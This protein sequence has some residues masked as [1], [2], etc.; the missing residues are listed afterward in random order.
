M[1]QLFSRRLLTCSVKLRDG[2]ESSFQTSATSVS[3]FNFP[4][5]GVLILDGGKS[6][7]YLRIL[8]AKK[9]FYSMY[10]NWD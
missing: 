6:K 7:V 10:R 5:S 3:G 2:D 4:D 9:T 1:H 8:Q